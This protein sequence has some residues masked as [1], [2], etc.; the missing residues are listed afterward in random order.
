[1]KT[2]NTDA[3]RIQEQ[4]TQ[5]LAQAGYNWDGREAQKERLA[6]AVFERR[7]I[8]TPTGGINGRHR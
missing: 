8:R 7:M 2:I 4:A 6:Q 3:R 1:M 5:L